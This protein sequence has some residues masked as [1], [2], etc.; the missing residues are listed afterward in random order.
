MQHADNA[1]QSWAFLRFASSQCSQ[2]ILMYSPDGTNAYGSSAEHVQGIG[3][4][5][6][7]ESCKIM[8]LDA[9]CIH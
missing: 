7:V 1:I 5:Y 2:Y 9:L 8:F 4:V 3:S 6:G